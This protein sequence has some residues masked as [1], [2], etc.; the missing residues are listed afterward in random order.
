ML[1]TIA[2]LTKNS[3]DTVR[4]A[5]RSIFRQKIPDNVTYELIVID[6]YSRDSTLNIVTEEVQKLREKFSNQYI[7]RIILQER[8]GVG[9][10]RNLALKEAQGDWI[11]W[12]DSDNI[13][14]CNYILKAIEEIE[15]VK[16]GNV[17]VLYPQRAIPV[18][19]KRNLASKLITCYNTILAY[20]SNSKFFVTQKRILSEQLKG[21]KERVLPYTGMQGT[22]CSTEA[23]RKV[24]G[25][26]PYLIA[27]EDV[28]L[29]LKLTNNDYNM[30]SFNS[31]LYYFTRDSF[32]TW[33]RQ[34]MTWEYGKIIMHI[35]NNAAEFEKVSPVMKPM[36]LQKIANRVI[37]S[38]TMSI[39][40]L[41]L[42]DSFIALLIPLIYTYRR[43][44]YFTG[45][46]HA[47][48]QQ[49]AISKLFQ[50]NVLRYKRA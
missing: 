31:T 44:G 43:L 29:L 20:Q 50:T 4:F 11:L 46:L 14:A 32:R 30:K 47:L 35:F 3:E 10:A 18:P 40:A 15:K 28:D 34:A 26:N 2:L 24:G 6:G 8:V 45:Y 17:A 5:L 33:F 13:L 23:L 22:F 38:I 12:I 49:E 25:F 21:S 16:Y 9:F 19:R 36:W 7:R 42:C 41:C 1:L 27:A 37:S 48:N 39:N